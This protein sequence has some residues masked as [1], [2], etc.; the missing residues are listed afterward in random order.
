MLL[1]S[2]VLRKNELQ[3]FH[4]FNN[5]NGGAPVELDYLRQAKVR[6]FFHPNNPDVCLAGYAINTRPPFRYLSVVDAETRQTLMN[7]HHWKDTD[8]AEITLIVKK[9]HFKWTKAERFI[10]YAHSIYD[11]FVTGREVILGGSKNAVLA[12]T[13]MQVLSKKLYMGSVNFF[14]K[15]E[16][17]WL[18][19]E[20]R[21][22][23][24]KNLVKSGIHI[25]LLSLQRSRPN[26]V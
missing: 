23:M 8:L 21:L 26:K 22:E 16:I 24:V 18:F 15:S 2:K 7:E 14:G 3:F 1:K 9:R 13:M 6:V 11:A 25:V 4:D 17:T 12:G 20:H 5:A 10:Y 19:Y